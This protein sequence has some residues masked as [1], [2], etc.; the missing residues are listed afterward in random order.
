MQQPGALEQVLPQDMNHEHLNSGQQ[1]DIQE[2]EWFIFCI[3][4][5]QKTS[6]DHATTEGHDDVHDLCCQ[7]EPC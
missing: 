2:E 3:K 5:P 6:T 1:Q 7:Q 4:P